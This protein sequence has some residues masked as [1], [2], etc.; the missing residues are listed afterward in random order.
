MNAEE[1]VQLNNLSKF[2]SLFIA[3]PSKLF[4]DFTL[5]R[6]RRERVQIYSPAASGAGPGDGG[7]GAGPHQ[8]RDTSS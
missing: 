4:Q 6:N 2:I 1:L 7:A 3:R 8:V 5:I